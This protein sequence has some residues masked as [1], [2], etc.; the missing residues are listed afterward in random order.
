M[1]S[2]QTLEGILSRVSTCRQLE[3]TSRGWIRK[4]ASSADCAAMASPAF[5]WAFASLSAPFELAFVLSRGC[6][7]L[8]WQHAQHEH[9]T[10]IIELLL[11]HQ[12]ESY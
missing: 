5:S 2:P 9:H 11:K 12:T 6:N 10:R 4:L 7:R 8:R 3:S 1:N